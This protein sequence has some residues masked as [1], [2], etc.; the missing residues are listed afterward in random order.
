MGQ[1]RLQTEGRQLSQWADLP[2]LMLRSC[3]RDHWGTVYGTPQR[4]PAKHAPLQSKHTSALPPHLRQRVLHIPRLC[5]LCC[6]GTADQRAGC[7]QQLIYNS[8]S[9]CQLTGS[10]LR[11]PAA[12]NTAYNNGSVTTRN[13]LCKHLQRGDIHGCSSC[14]IVLELSCNIATL[15]PCIWLHT[16]NTHCASSRHSGAHR[17][18]HASRYFCWCAR[19]MRSSPTATPSKATAATPRQRLCSSSR[20]ASSEATDCSSKGTA[21]PQP[22]SSNSNRQVLLELSAAT[23]ACMGQ[24]RLAITPTPSCRPVHADPI[25]CCHSRPPASAEVPVMAG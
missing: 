16:L 22:H 13:P 4:S 8:S 20:A 6:Q 7:E 14:C 15:Q 19:C 23:H 17:A 5:V 11:K 18:V 2:Y 12:S 24:K 1:E 10:H 3:C 25:L 9:L 21:V